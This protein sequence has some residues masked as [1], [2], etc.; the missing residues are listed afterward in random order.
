MLDE[1]RMHK[2]E[3]LEKIGLISSGESEE[4]VLLRKIWRHKK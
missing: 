2:L 3:E 4:L 1:K